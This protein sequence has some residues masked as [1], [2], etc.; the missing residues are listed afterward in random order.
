MRGTE[1]TGAPVRRPLPD[2]RR[3][4]PGVAAGA[5]RGRSGSGGGDGGS[6]RDVRARG[7][8]INDNR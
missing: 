7:A 4:P 5:Q 2:V 1:T 8:R 6:T 3:A